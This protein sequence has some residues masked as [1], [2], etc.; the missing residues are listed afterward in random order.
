MDEEM[1]KERIRKLKKD[2]MSTIEIIII[3]LLQNNDYFIIIYNIIDDNLKDSFFYYIFNNDKELQSI[4]FYKVLYIRLFYR[5][6]YYN[7]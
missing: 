6:N 5:Y 2:C 4:N 3:Q 7:I 1:E